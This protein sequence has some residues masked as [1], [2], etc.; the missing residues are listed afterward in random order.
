[1]VSTDEANV[2]VPQTIEAYAEAEQLLGIHANLMNAQT[3]KPMM[4]IVYDSLS[5]AYLLTYPEA[6]IERLDKEIGKLN[7]NL[8]PE[9]AITIQGHIERQ[10]ELRRRV[11]LDPV[12]F[13]AAIQSVTDAP[14]F[15]TLFQRLNYYSVNPYGGRA[16]IS[17]TL[18]EDFDYNANGVVIKNGILISGVLTKK[19]LGNVDGSIIGEMVK[20]LGGYATVDFMS[21]IQF[22]LRDYLQQRGLSVG[23]DDCIPNDPNFRNYLDEIVEDASFKVIALSGVPTNEIMAQEKERKIGNILNVAKDQGDKIVQK[24]FHP[25]NSIMIMSASGAKGTTFNAIQMSSMLGTVM[26]S[27]KRILANLPGNRALP[28]IQLNSQDPADRGFCANSFSSGLEPKEFWFH[29]QG[30]REGLTDTAVNTAQ[31]GFLQHQIIKSAEDVHI[32]PDGSVRVADNAVIQFIYGDDGL[33]GGSLSGVQIH[34]EKI[35]LFRNIQQ[36]ADKINRK[37]SEQI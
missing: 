31:T 30:G 7:T 37:Y 9:N 15:E 8:T 14:Q 34:G 2:H 5:G 1:L 13:N 20:Q 6:E 32:S 33:E 22:V 18:P 16:L 26:V 19:T 24:F 25:D 23:Y 29:M 36:V 21:D 4:G 10:E 11:T 27:G 3:N 17:A 28:S 35:P 12:I